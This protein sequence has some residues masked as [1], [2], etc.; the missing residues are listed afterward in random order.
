MCDTGACGYVDNYGTVV[1]FEWIDQYWIMT[2]QI[3]ADILLQKTLTSVKIL[4]SVS[5]RLRLNFLE[6][7]RFIQHCP[8]HVENTRSK[9]QTSF[10]F[11]WR[12]RQMA[13]T[14]SFPTRLSNLEIDPSNERY[15]DEYRW[16]DK[17]QD[18]SPSVPYLSTKSR[19]TCTLLK[20][21]HLR[22]S[23][24]QSRSFLELCLRAPSLNSKTVGKCS[25]FEEIRPIWRTLGAQGDHRSASLAVEEAPLAVPRPR[26]SLFFAERSRRPFFPRPALYSNTAVNLFI[27]L[28]RH[29]KF[30]L[31]KD[32]TPKCLF[33]FQFQARL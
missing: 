13:R 7:L 23:H 3:R 1:Y 5:L 16:D 19:D 25:I 29:L 31:S 32:F 28:F 9:F 30:L 4:Q 6:F 8:C 18:T 27:A 10:Q 15:W 2:I 14:F 22:P 26:G 24:A 20:C 21:L 33:F 12:E 17:R 11:Y